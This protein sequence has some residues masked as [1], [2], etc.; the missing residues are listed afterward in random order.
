MT[1]IIMNTIRQLA[2]AAD[3]MPTTCEE[4]ALAAR[5]SRIMKQGIE[6]LRIRQEDCSA[7]ERGEREFHY[8]YSDKQ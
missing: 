4:A 3:D 2:E 6:R 1:D 5:A 8:D 7:M